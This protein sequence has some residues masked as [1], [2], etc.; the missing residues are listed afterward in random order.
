MRGTMADQCRSLESR[1]IPAN[2]DPVNTMGT[3]PG[4]AEDVSAR[5]RVVY[6]LTA[7]AARFPDLDLAPL[8]TAALDV[9]DAAM[10]HAIYDDVLRHWTG[11]TFLL[12]RVLAK[13]MAEIE[14]KLRAVLLAGA[15]QILLMDRI[16]TYAAINESVAWAK[17]HVRPGAGALVNAVLRKIAA[18][19]AGEP[20]QRV[21]R[22]TWTAQRDEWPLPDGS[23]LVLKEPV[24]PEAM[25]L[26]LALATSH[27]PALIDAWF[28][29]W[30]EDLVRNL[31]W[32]SLAA[33]PIILNTMHAANPLPADL[34]VPHERPGHHVFVGDHTALVAMMR[35]RR[36]VWVQDPASAS[37]VAACR[38][39]AP[40][41]ILDLCAGTGTKTRQ[42]EAA[43]PHAE[44]IATDVDISRLAGLRELFKSSPRV[45]I[46]TR[47]EIQTRCIGQADLIL[48]D[49]PCSNTGVLAR[50][51]EAKHRA[52][53]AQIA[54][55]ADLQRQ[56]IADAIPLLA[57]G[58]TILYATC[59]IEPAE[60]E[61]QAAWAA[62]WH[63]LRTKAH[64]FWLPTGSPGGIPTIYH[65]GAAWFSLA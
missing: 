40:R 59:S 29:R 5:S 50:R 57:H 49:V 48:L 6:R 30:P 58:G 13:P 4:R 16:P 23:A 38:H 14:P 18:L 21:R 62:K 55:L 3:R 44:I 20:D 24:L 56:I 65:D 35:E 47:R 10:A 11:L 19:P 26:R 61:A 52:G 7:Q 33:P 42:L 15:A 17:R 37:T 28:A 32:H 34:L 43:F 25:P 27:P 41:R 46:L 39:L 63:N 22:E 8:D 51:V 12:D 2:E 53:P 36:D 64:A 45:S 60:N 54:R 1:V 31:A 9:R